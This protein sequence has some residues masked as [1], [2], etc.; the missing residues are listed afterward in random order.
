MTVKTAIILAAVFEFLG[1]ITLG[2]NVS[3]TLITGI[4]PPANFVGVEDKFSLGMFVSLISGSIWVALA[5]KY[6]LPVSTTHA[7]VGSIMGFGAVL[8]G[9]ARLPLSPVINGIVMPMLV[10]PVVGGCVAYMVALAVKATMTGPAVGKGEMVSGSV[11]LKRLPGLY[12]A[13]VGPLALMVCLDGTLGMPWWGAV[14]VGLVCAS[15]AFVACRMYVVPVYE[16]RFRDGVES[17]MSQMVELGHAEVEPLVEKLKDDDQPGPNTSPS[18]LKPSSSSSLAAAG[19]GGG[20]APSSS[21]SSSPS[22]GGL[23]LPSPAGPGPHS[24]SAPHRSLS[25]SPMGSGDPAD[26][27]DSL[28]SPRNVEQ[29]FQGPILFTS[30]YVAF[31]HGSNDVSNGIAPL[32]AILSVKATGAVAGSNGIPAWVLFVGGVGIVSGLVTWGVPVMRTVGEKVTKLNFSKS[33]CVQVTTGSVVLASSLLGLPVSTTHTLIGAL[34][35]VGMSSAGGGMATAIDLGTL[36]RILLSW[37]TTFPV[38]A[39]ISA[40]LYSICVELLPA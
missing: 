10:S 29:L 2:G 4:I 39:L 14:T 8:L 40:V 38:G 37:A 34:A 13:T 24:H 25:S 23:S 15:A 22:G 5:T 1:A 28:D 33:Y 11:A 35:G 18:L 12:A 26:G 9:L 21:S 7:L 31:A 6:E 3:S 30:A 17:S 16:V 36:K 27:G 19:N 32:A 20:H